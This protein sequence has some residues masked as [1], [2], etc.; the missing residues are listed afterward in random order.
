MS[1]YVTVTYGQMFFLALAMSVF[2]A[3]LIIINMM[4]M[5]Y[6]TLPVVHADI[7][8]ACLKVINFNNGDAYN[9]NDVG[10]ILRRYREVV[11]NEKDPKAAM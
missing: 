8:K 7:N 6:R 4:Y 9:C 2:S 11:V 5:D 3:I 10:V 1:K